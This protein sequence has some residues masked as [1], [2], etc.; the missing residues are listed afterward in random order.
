MIVP[1]AALSSNSCPVG[2]LSEHFSQHEFRDRRT[3][4]VYGPPA[5]LVAVL[6]RIRALRPGPLRIVSGHR[7]C[8]TN[9][10]VSQASESRHI[11]GDA[12]DIPSG[13]A[14]VAEAQAAGAVGI[15]SKGEWAIHVDVRPGPP[16]RWRY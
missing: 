12:A 13:R 15:G 7:C 3:G 6:E 8:S 14:T 11:A 1:T 16:A 9:A 2:D 5:E 10:V 4:H